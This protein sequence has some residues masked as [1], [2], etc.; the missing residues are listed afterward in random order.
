[1]NPADFTDNTPGRLVTH[2]GH[3]AF[4]PD[5]LP[6]ALEFTPELVRRLS[7]ADNGVGLLAGTGRNLTNPMLL[8]APYLRREAVLSSRIEGTVSTL[9]DLYEDEATGSARG[10]VRE[11]RNYLT[12]HEYGLEALEEM[13]LCL[14]LLRDV[15]RHLMKDVRGQE[16]HPGRFRTYQ[17]WIGR[18]AGA[19]IDEARYVPPPV[20][21]MKKALDDLETFLHS[22]SLPTLVVAA[23]AHYQFEAIH[24]FGDGNGRVGRLLI[25]LLLHER[26]LLPQP[27]LYISAYFERSGAEYYDRLLRVSTHGDWQGW[28]NYFLAGVEIQSQAAVED[29]ERLLDLQARYHEL[30]AQAKARAG[31]RQLI[32]RL[33]VN[34]Y[35]TASR[36]ATFLDV[37]RPTA[38]AAIRDL[39]EQGILREITGQKWGQV[40]MADEIFRAARGGLDTDHPDGN[41]ASV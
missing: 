26:G 39:I 35:I 1:M 7:K 20:A 18:K 25:S 33:F 38:R 31:A 21:E 32:D 5:P 4:V 9:A 37:S 40:F 27:L 10:D 24:P 30:L 29:A 23:L 2:D 22:D 3:Q 14:R 41:E 6:P 12:A 36:A 11:V 8:I 16:R 28:L 13:P 15:H 17:N 19:P 34:P